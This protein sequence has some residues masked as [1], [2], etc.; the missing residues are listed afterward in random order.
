MLSQYSAPYRRLTGRSAE[1][2]KRRRRRIRTI[3][4]RGDECCAAVL[5]AWRYDQK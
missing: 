3:P 1:D 2:P 5:T 4:L